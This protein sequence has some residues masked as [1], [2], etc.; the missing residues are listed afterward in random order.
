ML[1]QRNLLYFENQKKENIKFWK[2]LG[3]RPTLDGKTVL[4]FGCGLGCL[5]IDLI[6]NGAQSVTGIDLEPE[7]IEFAKANLDQNFGIFKQNVNF[8]KKDLLKEKFDKDFDIIVTKD[9]F[10]QIIYPKFWKNLK[11]CL[12]KMEK[13]ILVLAHYII[14]ITE[15]MEEHNLNFLG[16]MC[17]FQI[18]L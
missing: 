8:E 3:G 17:Y 1:E 6:N 5:S 9:T 2:R 14:F 13:L 11:F 12:K 16:C 7:Y 15:T 18:I 4:D 10:E